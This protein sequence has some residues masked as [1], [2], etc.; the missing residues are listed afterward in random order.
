MSLT[1]LDQLRL[2]AV[3]R[4]D[5]IAAAV[6]LLNERV[7]HRCS[8]VYA[9]RKNVLTC[10]VLV[11]KRNEA[12][13]ESLAAVP[14]DDSFCQFAFRDQSFRTDDA[15][16][17]TRLDG[18]PFQKIVIS[19]HGVPLMK[20]SGELYGSLCHFDFDAKPLDDDEFLSL[21]QAARLFS[22]LLT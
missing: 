22:P 2:E 15:P 8:A 10:T 3:L 12:T 18:N 9:L 11:D 20:A 14:L 1:K 4:T 17:D 5:G 7:P 16:A 6:Q 13:P 19:Y 21:Q